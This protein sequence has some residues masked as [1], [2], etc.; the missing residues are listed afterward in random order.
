MMIEP[1]ELIP[2]NWEAV[3]EELVAD[4]EYVFGFAFVTVNGK[5]FS[6]DYGI[7]IF[8]HNENAGK[9]YG[10]RLCVLNSKESHPRLLETFYMG[11]EIGFDHLRDC[12]QS[13]TQQS[14][15][16]E[17]AILHFKHR[18]TYPLDGRILYGASLFD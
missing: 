6:G 1:I 3:Y 13:P 10:L 2:E 17:G 16:L 12:I 15:E 4:V 7:A 14:P 11:E 9:F 5:Y 18:G 8:I